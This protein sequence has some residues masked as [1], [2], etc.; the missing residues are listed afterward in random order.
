MI[1][2]SHEVPFSHVV[3]KDKNGKNLMHT[4]MCELLLNQVM[5]CKVKLRSR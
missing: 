1:S 5:N 4:I 2:P 3:L